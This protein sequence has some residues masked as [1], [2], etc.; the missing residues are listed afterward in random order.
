MQMQQRAADANLARELADIVA[1]VGLQRRND[2][3]PLWI[4]ECR[5]CGE[6]LVAGDRCIGDL[7]HV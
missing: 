3:Q 5:Q 4:G 2:A 7:Y 6:Q 1:A